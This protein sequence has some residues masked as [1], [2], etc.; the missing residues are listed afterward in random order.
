M[1]QIEPDVDLVPS[2]P[3]IEIGVV[4]V[5]WHWPALAHQ[6]VYCAEN[7][8]FTGVIRADE[9]A[10]VLRAEID[11]FDRAPILDSN[12]RDP[13]SS[14]LPKNRCHQGRF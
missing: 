2:I 9:D 1:I 5:A 11:I 13:H 3:I 6:K 10:D 7:V 8:R 4:Q 14:M 12:P